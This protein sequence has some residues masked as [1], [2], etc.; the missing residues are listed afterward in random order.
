MIAGTIFV[1]GTLGEHIGA[2]MK[3][4]TI[5]SSQLLPSLSPGFHYACEYEPAYMNILNERFRQTGFE[6]FGV[7]NA[8][9]KSVRCYRGDLLTGGCGEIWQVV[10]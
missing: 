8:R 7:E 2:G 10:R 6:P 5:I 4:G 1:G 3:R 9:M